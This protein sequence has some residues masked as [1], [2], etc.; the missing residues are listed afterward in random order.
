MK[1]G[2]LV[3]TALPAILLASTA[4][5]VR[6]PDY[7]DERP[8]E[9]AT[10]GKGRFHRAGTYTTPASAKASFDRFRAAHG[11]WKALWDGDTAVPTRIF[12]EG[13]A[14]PGSM[15]DGAIAEAAAKRLLAEQIDLLAPGASASDFVVIGNLV[16]GGVRTVSFGQRWNGLEVVSSS[17]RFM[18]KHD[19]IASIASTAT[20][21]ISATMPASLASAST[22]ESKAQGWVDAAYGATPTVLGSSRTA[23]LLPIHR[24]RGA[25]LEHR[26]VLPVTVDLAS[27][28]GKWIVYVDAATA[29]PVARRQTLMFA[30]G[31]VRYRVPPRHPEGGYEDFVAQ[32][33]NHQADGSPVTSD[34]AGLFSWT[35]AAAATV[36][37]GLAGPYARIFNE[38]GAN[39]TGSLNVAPDGSAVWDRSSVEFEDAQLA[40]YIHANVAKQFGKDNMD[41][42]LGWLFQQIPVHPNEDSTCNAYSNLDDIHFFRAGDGCENTARLA[43]V[44]YHE[45]GHSI[46]GQSEVPGTDFDGAMS[47]GVS[48]VYAALITGDPAMGLGF[49]SPTQPLRHIDPPDKE[50]TWPDDSTGQ[51]HNDGHIISGA[52]WDLRKALIAQLGE[53]EGKDLL[54]EMYYA[55][56]SRADDMLSC[57]AE[58]LLA[59]D[60]NGNIADGTPHQCAID[61]AFALHGLAEGAAAQLGAVAPPSVENLTL[62]LQQLEDTGGDCPGPQIAAAHVEWHLRSEPG[63]GGWVDFTEGGTTFAATIPDQPDG[64]VI[65]YQVV[66]EMTDGSSRTLPQNAADPWYEL[67]VGPVDEIYCTDFEADP[68]AG[69]WLYGGGW[70]WGDATAPAG[71]DDPA[72][73]YSG[74]KVLG[75]VLG[76]NYENNGTFT[77][78]SPEIDVA[79][80]ETIRLQ[81]RRWLNVEDAEYDHA[82]IIVEGSTAPVPV[83][84][85]LRTEQGST[86]HRDRE[87]RFQDVDLTGFGADGTL[88]VTFHLDSDQ[89]L[90]FGGWTIDDFCIVTQGAPA[91]EC[92]D[93]EIDVDTEECDDGNL[94]DGDDCSSLC[95]LP[96]GGGGGCCS[97]SRDR[98]IAGPLLLAFGTALFVVRRRRRR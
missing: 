13:I 95:E 91:P 35:G 50:W 2:H 23:L 71:S 7:L 12:G 4:H 11:S 86:N 20:P 74:T 27:P 78:R 36:A 1:R 56:I 55:A 15:A 37:P 38:A 93:G 22:A 29:E 59:D 16:R 44:V 32:F 63:T 68:V 10:G 72:T 49:F 92:G 65:Q 73:A 82:Q 40:S 47:E 51:V 24:E 57:Y 30:S 60:D 3:A 87:W 76:G 33:T 88:T 19:R 42:D 21:H 41:P 96:G 79:G 83:W 84:T 66:A 61:Q 89:G 62:T 39:V 6:Q 26:V 70:S 54:H 77:V 75:Q 98:G 64:T 48:D 28:R 17:V 46:H 94:A 97:T 80:Y 8:L 14:A 31:T 5:A 67:Y 52:F 85:N 34:I 9:T 53:Q 69:G 45:F 90:E 43:D 58:V 18:F 25:A 81:Y